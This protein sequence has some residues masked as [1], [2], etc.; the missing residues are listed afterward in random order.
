MRSHASSTQK[1]KS[2]I[3]ERIDASIATKAALELRIDEEARG[4]MPLVLRNKVAYMRIHASSAERNK[5]AYMREDRREYRE[6]R[7][8]ML[9][10]L[11]RR[12]QHWCGCGCLV[13]VDVPAVNIADVN[14]ADVGVILEDVV[15]RRWR[16]RSK[17]RRRYVGLRYGRSRCRCRAGTAR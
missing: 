12:S 5:V 2:P 14:V 8:T 1:I 11:S 3:C 17:G 6:A 9:R 4:T 13:D 7:G 15:C 10:A 16:S